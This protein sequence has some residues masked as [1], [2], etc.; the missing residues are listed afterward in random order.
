MLFLPLELIELILCRLNYREISFVGMTC[1]NLR[2]LIR[3]VTLWQKLLSLRGTPAN[4]LT[5]LL[6]LRRRYQALPEHD[7][8]RL[9]I[10]IGNEIIELGRVTNVIDFFWHDLFL[11]NGRNLYRTS[12]LTTSMVRTYK[13]TGRVKCDYLPF[14]P[15]YLNFTSSGVEVISLTGRRWTCRRMTSRSCYL[16][17]NKPGEFINNEWIS[18]LNRWKLVT[19]KIIPDKD[20]TLI[21]VAT[22]NDYFY[23]L[24]IGKGQREIR[25][26]STYSIREQRIMSE[27]SNPPLSIPTEVIM[28]DIDDIIATNN[29]IAFITGKP[30]SM[31]VLV[32]S[33]QSWI[34]DV[35]LEH[36]NHFVLGDSD[37][38]YSRDGSFFTKDGL[39]PML[40]G[41]DEVRIHPYACHD[42]FLLLVRS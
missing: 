6:R 36:I 29:Q 27:V 14:R 26:M 12:V 10:L 13:S 9:L 17:T 24:V 4:G 8:D 11:E 5:S 16:Q 15:H 34:H 22:T 1:R 38:L 33:E 2:R 19:Y 31:K 23:F 35:T 7:G 25:R 30:P 42:A 39:V 21:K 28:I 18:W 20:T 37:Y 41:N 3:D 32:R 40:S